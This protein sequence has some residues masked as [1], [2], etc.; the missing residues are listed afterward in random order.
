[1]Q[2]LKTLKE[3]AIDKLSATEGKDLDIS[4][5][6]THPDQ[7]GVIL[8]SHAHSMLGSEYVIDRCDLYKRLTVSY[9]GR[10]RSD[11]VTIGTGP[12]FVPQ[13]SSGS[14]TNFGGNTYRW[15]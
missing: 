13:S 9:M 3:T 4:A 10:Y 12:E 14:T 8:E 7:I 1:M 5:N 11:I 15:P 2:L 6:L